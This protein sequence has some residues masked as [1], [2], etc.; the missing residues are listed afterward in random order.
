MASIKSTTASLGSLISSMSSG[1][2]SYT[3]AIGMPGGIPI[4]DDSIPASML[5]VE[6]SF[7]LNYK[8]VKKQCIKKAKDSITL[9]VKEVVPESLQNSTLIIDKINQDAE[10]LGA[11]YYEYEK[12]DK[13]VQA[14]IDTI[15]HGQLQA[16]LFEVYTKFS[17]INQELSAQITETQNQLRKYYID[18]YLD[19]QEKKDRE[20]ALLETDKKPALSAPNDEIIHNSNVIVGTEDLTKS[21]NAKK[22][23]ALLAQYEEQQENQ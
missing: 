10:Q 13:V 16:R 22:K 1:S 4:D 9:V 5:D 19:L 15:A 12:N 17:K 20:H 11:L 14:L 18:T 6:P 8:S 21:L 23:A 7:K 3:A 2:G